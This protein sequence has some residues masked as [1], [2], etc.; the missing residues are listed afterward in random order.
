MDPD[1]TLREILDLIQ[2]IQAAEMAN[3][4][5]G[6][7]TGGHQAEMG[8]ELANKVSDLNRWIEDGGFLPSAWSALVTGRDS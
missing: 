8:Q 3:D 4:Y 7:A 1:A 6:L 5:L 2:R